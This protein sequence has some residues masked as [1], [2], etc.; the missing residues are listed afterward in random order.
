MDSVIRPCSPDDWQRFC[1]LPGLSPLTPQL[2]ERH[3]PDA[4]LLL[5][6]GKGAAARC[7]LWWNNAPQCAGNRLGLIGHY[8][9]AR[10]GAAAEV[11]RRACNVLAEQGCTLAV[12]PM[13]G[14]T[15]RRYRL[16]TERGPEPPFFLEPDNPDDWPAHFTDN[17]F[18]PLAQYYS[19]LNPDLNQ[20]DP[21]ADEA[22]E[23]L[24]AR[25]V[26]LRPLR[27][28][29]FEE[30][31]RLIYPLTL[32]SFRDNFL[33][34]PLTAEEFL[35]M[36]RGLAGVLPSELQVLAEQAG[37]L[38]GFLLAAPDLLQKQR[39]VPVDTVVLKTMA[40]HPDHGGAGLG[41]LM[42]ARC[43]EQAA[44]M[45]FRRAIHAL[46]HESNRSRR[47]SGRT[48]QVMRRYTLFARP[49]VPAS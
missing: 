48:A 40:V 27:L 14:N 23:R 26:R 32:L 9:A 6:E 42:M 20:R 41:G 18:T 15:W 10:P 7:S 13:D 4:S 21:R 8:A 22:A 31:L 16:L 28:D 17:G 1:S 12:G 5:T 33:Y 44:H 47:L 39:G 2:C 24:A 38:V 43:Q 3:A 45:G 49:L 37:T 19:A 46:M 25:D 30:E 11:L 36:Y 35:T 34:T 29:R